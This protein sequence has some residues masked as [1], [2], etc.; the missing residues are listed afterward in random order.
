M[1]DTYTPRTGTLDGAMAPMGDERRALLRFTTD[2]AEFD[3]TGFSRVDL[4]GGNLDWLGSGRAPLLRDHF[5]QTD[6][7]IGVVEAAWI[8][9]GEARAV[10]RFGRSPGADAAWLD[11]QAGVL[12]SVSMGFT[13]RRADVTPE[14]LKIREWEPYEISLVALP[15]CRGARVLRPLLSNAEHI[16]LFAERNA[17]LAA[18]KKDAAAQRDAALRVPW[19]RNWAEVSAP[20]IAAAAGCPVALVAPVLAR[21]VDEHLNAL[22]AGPA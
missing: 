4:A 17:A 16:E 3:G 14:G 10:V 20:A 15:A 18:V 19:W 5:R 8:H 11:V 2:E 6:A 12:L 7:V 1:S 21:L 9:D 22:R 13:I